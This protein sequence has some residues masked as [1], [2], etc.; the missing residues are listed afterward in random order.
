M[1]RSDKNRNKYMLSGSLANNGYDWWWHNFTGID[2]DSGEERS[3]FIEYYVCNPDLGGHE[4]ILGQ[5]PEN[6]AVGIRPSYAMLKAGSWGKNPKQIHNFYPISDLS[7]FDGNLNIRVGE[8]TLSETAMK[9]IVS[10]S[11]TEALEHPE[12]MCDAGTLKWDLKINKTISF[13]V[14]Y[15]ASPFFRKINAFEMFWHAEGIKT[16]YSGTVEWN[17]RL[18]EVTPAASFG[19]SDKNWGKDF[20]SPWLWISS[21]DMVSRKKGIRLLNSAV[22]FGGGRPKI[23][24]FALNRKILGSLVYEGEVFEYNFSR[25]WNRSRVSFHFEEGKEF[26]KWELFASNRNSELELT[27]QCPAEE[28]LLINYESPDGYKRH[29]RLWNGGTAGGIIRLY[30]GRGNKRVLM[31]TIDISHTGCE[32]GEYS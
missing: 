19:Y 29:N 25:F 11:E 8:A 14:G 32:Y 7:I 15:G 5:L 1:N 6:R 12:W 23:F 30:K 26:H 22:E 24:G 4:V 16:E 9:G 10:V 31:D 18:F 27:L 28:M 20:T 13:N 21:C 3:F 17:G 2:K